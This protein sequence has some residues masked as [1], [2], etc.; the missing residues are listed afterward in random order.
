MNNEVIIWKGPYSFFRNGS[1]IFQEE[2]ALKGGLYMWTSET[3]RGPLVNYIGISKKSLSDRLKSHVQ[4]FFSGKY[5]IYD[6]IE[7]K[8]GN[9]KSLF[10]PTGNVL[11][12]ASQ[13]VR[14]SNIIYSFVDS[15][16]LYI[17]NV[18]ADADY[19][20]RIESGIILQLWEQQDS[21]RSFLDNDRLSI[22]VDEKDKSPVTMQFPSSVVGIPDQ[23]R[24]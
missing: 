3:D 23:V 11:D 12:F 24:I 5:Y 1:S 19:L 20:R 2:I 10:V 8:N 13:F 4:A 6:P 14:L 15:I 16:S 7:F 18:E 9:L 17:A 22:L 21:V